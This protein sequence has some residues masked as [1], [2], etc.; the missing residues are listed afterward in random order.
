MIAGFITKALIG[1]ILFPIWLVWFGNIVG[2]YKGTELN[3]LL[4]Q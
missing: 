3:T 2:K 1:L 4:Q